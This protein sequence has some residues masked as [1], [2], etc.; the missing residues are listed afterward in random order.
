MSRVRL[1]GVA[2]AVA[3]VVTVGLVFGVRA[4]SASRQASGMAA[5]LVAPGGSAVW[6]AVPAAKADAAFERCNDDPTGSETPGDHPVL[7]VLGAGRI[8]P[9]VVVPGPSVP[10]SVDVNGGPPRTP[11]AV[12]ATR[13]LVTGADVSGG[14]ALTAAAANCW[15]AALD[16]LGARVVVGR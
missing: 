1:A 16:G 4:E 8:L 7:L 12:L 5:R 9:T 3:G 2:L 14:V 13:D 15:R 6:V 10:A 11:I